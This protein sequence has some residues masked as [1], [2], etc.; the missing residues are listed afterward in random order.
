M[1]DKNGGIQKIDQTP[2]ISRP[3]PH[4]YLTVINMTG[5]DEIRLSQLNF[6]KMEGSDRLKQKRHVSVGE[7]INLISLLL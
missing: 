1:G 5:P 6:F 3:F 4:I 2:V 7:N